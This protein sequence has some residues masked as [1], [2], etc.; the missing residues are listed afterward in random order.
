MQ[1]KVSQ[2]ENLFLKENG[3]LLIRVNTFKLSE[4]HIG[5]KA[6]IKIGLIQDSSRIGKI[7]KV[8]P[9]I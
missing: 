8:T 4:D 1:L 3:K 7:T 9:A 6:L 2:G 5:C